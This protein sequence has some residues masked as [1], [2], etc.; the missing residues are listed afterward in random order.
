[1]ANEALKGPY[2]LAFSLYSLNEVNELPG[3]LL[4]TALAMAPAAI[5]ETLA[6]ATEAEAAAANLVL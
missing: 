5:L 2:V 6:E 4:K 1:M 3:D